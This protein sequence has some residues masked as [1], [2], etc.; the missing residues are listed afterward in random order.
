MRLGDPEGSA[1]PVPHAAPVRPI[2]WSDHVNTYKI[3][4]TSKDLSVMP[5]YMSTPDCTKTCMAD[6]IVFFE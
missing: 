2:I 5:V 6:G 3:K 1:S 4:K